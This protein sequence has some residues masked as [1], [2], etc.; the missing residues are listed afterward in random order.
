MLLLMIPNAMVKDLIS[1]R[2]WLQQ[3]VVEEVGAKW[4][5]STNVNWANFIY[6]L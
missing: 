4:G 6:T 2:Q 5:K 3:G 1:E